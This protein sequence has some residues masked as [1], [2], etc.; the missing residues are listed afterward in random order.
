MSTSIVRTAVLF[1]LGA[2]LLQAQTGADVAGAARLPLKKASLFSSG[3]AY[4]EHSGTVT[5]NERLTLPFNT[6]TINDA[7]KSLVINDTDSGSPS[8]NYPSETT[9]YRTLKNLKIDLST[10][11]GLL[12]MLKNLQGAEIII[13]AADEEGRIEQVR[14]RIVAVE[15]RPDY[16]QTFISLA[17]PQ[18]VRLINIQDVLNLVFTD[19]GISNDLNRALDLLS[20]ARAQRDHSLSIEL[21]GKRKREVRVSYVIPSPVWKISYRLDLSQT[22]P[23]LQAWAIIDNDSD[24]DWAEVEL[25]LVSGKPVSFIQPLYPP[26]YLD[27]PTLP[28]SGAGFADAE[29]FESGYGTASA[30]VA[31]PESADATNFNIRDESVQYS[32]MKLA[33]PTAR[34]PIPAPQASLMAGSAG[35]V[36]RAQ[37]TGEQF[38]F[39]LKKPVTLGRQQSAMLPIFEGSIKARKLFVFSGEKAAA[40][41]ALHPSISAELSNSSGIKLPAGAITVFDGGTYAGDALLDFFNEN[42]KRLISYGDDLSMSG[43]VSS[44]ATRN[45][46]S[47]QIS[48][49]LLTVQR[50][51]VWERTYTIRNGSAAAKKLIIEHPKTP[52]TA[53]IQPASFSEQTDRLYRFEADIRANEIFTLDVLEERALFEKI[54]LGNLQTETLF[55]YCGNEE[56]PQDVRA[57]LLEA[58]RLKQAADNAKKLVSERET[59]RQFQISEQERIRANL[60][61]VGNQSPEGGAYLKRLTDL[62]NEIE[63]SASAIQ[64]ARHSAELSQKNYDDYIAAIKL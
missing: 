20:G 25:S 53:L 37:Q 21:P 55:A 28:I 57:V 24:T 35:G 27:R 38:E 41:G 33:A 56:L 16:G 32:R 3:V 36:A 14:G 40:G 62:D 8:I 1:F 46:S 54:M 42:E 50:K 18:G 15:D 5:G 47:V 7:L 13:R 61:A 17:T 23:L 6:N 59:L 64:E 26:A 48:G 63:T 9:L 60:A 11:G 34:A 31:V 39:T 45:I 12:D 52:E 29:N 44:G 30:G 58:Y 22:S 2:S 4:F 43:S 51:L 10:Q 49:G 19:S